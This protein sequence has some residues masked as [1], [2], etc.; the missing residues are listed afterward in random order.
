MSIQYDIISP[1]Q[2]QGTKM[3]YNK[4][5][6]FM[7]NENNSNEYNLTIT[8]LSEP[9]AFSSHTVGVINEGLILSVFGTYRRPQDLINHVQK[10]IDDY[11]K[12]G[13][14][15]VVV[16]TPCN[17]DFK[18]P[19]IFPL[20]IFQDAKNCNVLKDFRYKI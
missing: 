16:S 14:D 7:Q 17:S 15:I 18:Q 5:I 2:K 8:R 1:P 20:D 19:F 11:H 6:A 9:I 10:N 3:N 12:S 13:N 4:M